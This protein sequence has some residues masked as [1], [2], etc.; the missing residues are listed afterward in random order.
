MP[1]AKILTA[2]R[3]LTM[4]ESLSVATAVAVGTDGRIAA[5]GDLD[6]CHAALPDADVVDLGSDVLLPGFV[7]SHSHPVLSGVTTQPPAYWIAPY[8]GYP[9]WSAVTD[10]FRKVHAELPADQP[11]MFNGF[12][13][14]LHGSN[15]P[16]NTVLDEFFPGR[17]AIVAD[18]SGH[19]VYFSSATIDFLGWDGKPPADPVGGSFGRNPDGTSNGQAFEVPAMMAVAQKVMAAAVAH[20]LASAAQWYALMAGNGI[21]STSEMTYDSTQKLAFEALASIP[22]CPLRI[23]LYHMSTTD[24]CG[25]TWDSKVP[26]QM[27]DKRGIKLWADGSP[28]VGN[29]ALTFPY[30]D[31]PATRAAGIPA[32]VHGIDEMNYTR[33]QL[34]AIIDRHA[35]NGWQF[36]VHV[37]GDAALDIVLDAFEDG[38]KRH[39]LLG[40]D[41]RWRLEHL[42]AARPD[43]FARAA[44]IGVYVSMGPFQFQYWG[45]LLDGQMFDHEH[46][47]EWCRVK[48]ATDAGLRPSY[49]NDGSVSPPSP[50]DNIKTVVTRTTQSGTA[51]GT[52]QCVTVDQ[53]LRAQTIDA[54][55]ILRRDHE[56]G[57]IEVG[58]FADFVQLDCD[59]HDVDPTEINT[60]ISVCAT[61]LNG[62]RIDL[63]AFESAAGVA[64][65]EPHR[66]LA[67]A[68]RHCC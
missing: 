67:V 6:T 12:D 3:I 30:L 7:E 49:H 61:W 31:T 18:N 44:K 2:S 54:A 39:N 51:R 46:G 13:R 38:L 1:T 21:T 66:H 19:A 64:D 62:E 8:V 43:Q 59:P 55:F 34:D 47:S 33:D 42:G 41:H 53:A 25:D 23:S 45:D 15:A 16:T 40:T 20:P 52:D 65:P 68:H 22:N 29:I 35:T 56:V 10:L 14:L 37:N 28:W 27:L 63:A 36:A 50:L 4:D 58:K 9:T 11:A 5:V 32:G 24:D 57:S 60:A 48:D 26:R 17:V